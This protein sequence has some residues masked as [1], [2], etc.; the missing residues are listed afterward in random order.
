[1]LACDSPPLQNL[2]PPDVC[3]GFPLLA[4]N[5]RNNVRTTAATT[6]NFLDFET[7]SSCWHNDHVGHPANNLGATKFM[8]QYN[9]FS[10]ERPEFRSLASRF[11]W[12]LPYSKHV[13]LIRSPTVT[14]PEVQTNYFQ[15]AALTN[16]LFGNVFEKA[17]SWILAG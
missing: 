8:A 7:P 11:E 2:A 10:T 15:K 4:R 3:C 1:M 16:E 5:E 6:L 14:T 13:S 17:L 9:Q 12:K